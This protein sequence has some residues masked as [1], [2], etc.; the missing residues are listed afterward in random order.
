M[1]SIRR[2]WRRDWWDHDRSR[3][4]RG[5]PEEEELGTIAEVKV[6][7][8][9]D[10]GRETEEMGGAIHSGVELAPR[11]PRAAARVVLEDQE[12]PSGKA[13]RFVLERAPQG[14]GCR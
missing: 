8:L 13:A 11:P 12:E 14:A 6:D 9:R 1:Y 4:G 10:R 7:C 5:H 3:L 2:R